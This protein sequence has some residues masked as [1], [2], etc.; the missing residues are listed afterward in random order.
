M[1][2][3][4][5]PAIPLI[6]I[7]AMAGFGSGHTTQVMAYDTERYII[8]EFSELNVEFL[9]RAKGSSMTPKYNSGDILGCKRLP[10]DTFFQ[11]GKVYVID[12]IQGP[13][14]KRVFKSDIPGHIVCVSDNKD[15]P[16]FEIEFDSQVN[17]IAIVLGV[18]RLE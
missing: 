9:I 6:P 15:Y 13:L 10:M 3:P 5:N 11:W 1:D 12:T 17:A 4:T 8:P 18:I 16:P 2:Q 14:V 7:D